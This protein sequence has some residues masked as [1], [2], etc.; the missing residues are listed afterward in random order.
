VENLAQIDLPRP[1]KVAVLGAECTGKTT[2]IQA[3][4]NCQQLQ[5]YEIR[6]IPE[7]LRDFCVKQGRTPTLTEQQPLLEAQIAALR[8][9]TNTAQNNHRRSIVVSDSAP[10]VTAL[11]SQMYFQDASL[12]VRATEFAKQ[13]IDLHLVL[14][15]E[16]SWSADPLPFMRDGPAAQLQFNQLLHDWLA[17]TQ[18]RSWARLSGSL[19]ERTSSA[20]AAI[21]ATYARGPE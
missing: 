7:L 9:E 8:D 20:S 6:I 11:Y 3:L 5:D 12:I 17:Q 15:P 19:E 18:L 4:A 14:E 10:I 1:L 2:L 16:F 21:V 13:Q